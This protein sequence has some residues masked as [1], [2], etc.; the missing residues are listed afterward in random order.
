M[1]AADLSYYLIAAA[2]VH[3]VNLIAFVGL[4]QS[5]SN[6]RETREL[7]ATM[8]HMDGR[9]SP[10]VVRFQTEHRCGKAYSI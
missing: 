7:E 5:H 3:V 9:T 10:A 8:E 1:L 6:A 4:D 2:F